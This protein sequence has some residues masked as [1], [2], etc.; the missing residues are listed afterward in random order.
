MQPSLFI[1]QVLL[2]YTLLLAIPLNRTVPVQSPATEVD[3][4]LVLQLVNKHRGAGQ[5]CGAEYL[6]PTEP[7]AWSAKLERAA[8]LHALDMYCQNY[9]SHNSKDGT[10]FHVRIRRQAY[11]YFTCA[12]N[13]GL[14]YHT[15]SDVIRG[16]VKSPGHCANL[17]N[18]WYNE[19]AV[20]RAGN[21]WV[22]LLAAPN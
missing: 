6:P 10:P 7:L 21:Y 12:E 18:N 4:A 20:A 3:K 1:A 8:Q 14:G 13:I 19:V 22:M 9:F 15:E 5:L 11:N 2:V 16:W 17:M